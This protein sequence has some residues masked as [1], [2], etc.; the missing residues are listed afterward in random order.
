MP[1][2]LCMGVSEEYVESIL[3][4]V[5]GLPLHVHAVQQALAGLPLHLHDVAGLWSSL[6]PVDW[7]GGRV[8][9]ELEAVGELLLVLLLLRL[10]DLVLLRRVLHQRNFLQLFLGLVITKQ[11]RTLNVVQE[12]FKG[13]LLLL[14]F[15]LGFLFVPV[16]LFVLVLP[17]SL[18]Q[19]G[20]V[21]SLP[22][23]AGFADVEVLVDL[24]D[25]VDLLQSLHQP[26]ELR[27]RAVLNLK[28]YF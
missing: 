3:L 23:G 9:R 16:F 4:H 18:L 15:S 2:L 6:R 14:S 1:D 13:C 26:N 19:G 24:L 21:L 12:L 7:P 10:F 20:V 11:L 27:V 28:G 17:S 5:L 25:L 8:G 22:P